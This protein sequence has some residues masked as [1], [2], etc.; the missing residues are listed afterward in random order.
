MQKN[1]PPVNHVRVHGLMGSQVNP[2]RPKVGPNHPQPPQGPIWQPLVKGSGER[3]GPGVGRTAMATPHLHLPCGNISALPNDGQ[4]RTDLSN[5][6]SAIQPSL[7][8]YKRRGDSS[9]STHTS[10]SNS[11]IPY[12]I[13]S[14]SSGVRVTIVFGSIVFSEIPVC[15]EYF[16]LLVRLQL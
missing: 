11:L 14:S 4:E 8:G 12:C 6:Q 16:T 9:L 2:N 13:I 7:G 3:W 15:L 1:I 10:R 5:R